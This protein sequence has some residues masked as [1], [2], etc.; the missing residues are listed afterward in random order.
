MD[1]RKEIANVDVEYEVTVDV[2]LGVRTNA[3]A[4]HKSVNRRFANVVFVQ[5]FTE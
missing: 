3:M 1:A 5:E 4:G 2:F